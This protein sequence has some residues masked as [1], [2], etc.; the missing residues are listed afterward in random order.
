MHTDIVKHSDIYSASILYSRKGVDSGLQVLQGI[1]RL[2]H[3]S[4][5]VANYIGFCHGMEAGGKSSIIDKSGQI[6]VQADSEEEKLVMGMNENEKW[7]GKL[8]KI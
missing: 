1:A 5:L 3:K 6:I 7:T 2:I 8:L 4:V